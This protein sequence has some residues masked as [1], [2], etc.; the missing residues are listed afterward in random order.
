MGCLK[1]WIYFLLW[2]SSILAGYAALFCPLLPILIIS[3]KLYR[4]L[5]D[6]FFTFW[7]SYPTALLEIWCG[8]DIQILGDPIHADEVSLLVMNHRTRT[9][10]NFLWPAVYHCTK[11]SKRY[12]HPTK[13]VLKD[14]I[15][16]LPGIGWV[17][18]L[19][20]FLYIKRNWSHDR[21]KIEGYIDYFCDIYY[22]YSLLIF[23][24]GTD[25]TSSTRVSSNKYA[26]KNN[27]T[28]YDYVLH[29]RTTGFVW[30]THKLIERNALDAVY[31]LTLIYPDTVPQTEKILFT[32]GK[33]P[34]QVKMHF[35]RYPVAVL[36]KTK[37]ELKQFLEKR[38]FEKEKVLKEF[39]STGHFLHGEILRRT[40]ALDLYVSLIFWTLLPYIVLYV[41][42]TYFWFKYV[43]ITH[44]ILLLIIN[45]L[46]D[47]F[48]ELEI[49]LYN[50][51]K[52]FFLNPF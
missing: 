40:N 47:G 37:D 39:H 9:D 50:L 3:N 52:K 8:C 5:T 38:W 14:I 19:S 31:D 26:E 27:L 12:K 33:F 51:K 45:Y 6:V 35:T 11:G 42:Y 20:C 24:E 46:T 28:T 16:H 34:Q 49:G 2:Y 10:W 15:R 44:T 30:V 4:F 23:P 41:V 32:D 48:P 7:Q 22:K 21:S 17:M 25:F 18:Q 13:F 1:G 36:P 29:P 43:V